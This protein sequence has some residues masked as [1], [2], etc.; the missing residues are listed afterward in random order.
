MLRPA[1]GEAL[2]RLIEKWR[3]HAKEEAARLADTP[4][5]PTAMVA[6]FNLCADELEAA[7]APLSGPVDA[8]GEPERCLVC[9]E[10]YAVGGQQ[11]R[12]PFQI[13]GPTFQICRR[14]VDA[15]KTARAAAV[16]SSPAQ[17]EEIRTIVD[18]RRGQRNFHAELPASEYERVCRDIQAPRCPKCLNVV[19]EC[20]FC[21]QNQ[22]ALPPSSPAQDSEHARVR[23]V[24]ER[25]AMWTLNDD[26]K[27]LIDWIQDVLEP[28]M[29]PPSS[30]VADGWLLMA[31][32]PEGHDHIIAA[33]RDGAQDEV[34]EVL[35]VCG[36]WLCLMSDCYV[37]P[38]HW[39]PLP[40]AP[41]PSAGAAKETK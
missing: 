5:N 25:C 3:A 17:E 7:L 32:L 16:P 11:T 19:T 23:E 31:M 28:F 8:S 9:K 12:S 4:L 6:T 18:V 10:V 26:P 24:W 14:C 35:L 22:L 30:P 40:S 1:E 27:R 21:Y 29:A 20:A 15:G 41:S 2:R 33:W 13:S 39:M 38:T 36:Q 34:G 37:T